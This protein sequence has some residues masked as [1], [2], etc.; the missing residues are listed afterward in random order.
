MSPHPRTSSPRGLL[1]LLSTLLVVPVGAALLPLVAF[2]A[3][4]AAGPDEATPDPA[5]TGRYGFQRAEYDLPKVDVGLGTPG[6]TSTTVLSMREAG[7]VYYP[8]TGAGPFPV[9]VFEHG[10]HATCDS[11]STA[12][13]LLVTGGPG[14]LATFEDGDCSTGDATADAA[15]AI[16]EARSYQGYDYLAQ[17]LATQGYIVAS[18]DVNDITDWTNNAAESGY[19]A[20]A[21]IISKTLDLVGSWNTRTGPAGIGDG[22]RGR[23]GLGLGVGVMGHSRGGEGVNMFAEYNQTRP[24]T[25]A[26]AASRTDPEN[27]DLAQPVPDVGPRYDLEAVFSLA[28]V[29]DQGDRRPVVSGTNFATLLPYCDGDV[30]DLEG[31]PVFERSKDGLTASGYAAAQYVVNGANHNYFNTV[32]T[33]DDANLFGFGDPNCNAEAGPT[34]LQPAE[35]RQVGLT[36]IGGFLRYWVGGETQFAPIVRGES[37]PPA[38]CPNDGADPVAGVSCRNIVQTSYEAPNRLVLVEPTGTSAAPTVPTTTPAGDPITA[39]GLTMT[40]CTPT[41]TAVAATT[42]CGSSPNRS[43]GPQLSLSWTAASALTVAPQAAHRDISAF[44]TL[45]FRI[46]PNFTDP[47]QLPVE[48]D[49]TVSL[50]DTSGKGATVSSSSYSAALEPPPGTSARK[51]LLHGVRIPLSAFTGIDLTSIKTISLG[52][53]TSALS[54]GSVQLNDLVLQEPRSTAGTD[55]T[56]TTDP[57][58]PAE[59]DPATTAPAPATT[60]TASAAAVPAGVARTRTRTRIRLPRPFQTLGAKPA[61]LKFQVVAAQVSPAS[62]GRVVVRVDGK[63]VRTLDAPVTSKAG[64]SVAGFTYRMSRH[65]SVGTHTVRVRFR[66]TDATRYTASKSRLITLTVTGPGRARPRNAV[67]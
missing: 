41:P 67:G 5:T 15:L 37:L 54:S 63:K 16:Q 65:L 21:Q 34:R 27:P 52:F 36:L 40:A 11:G 1:R 32:W 13:D 3:P 66:P 61:T 53:G 55:P 46:A 43:A 29:D 58:G 47:R 56:E 60:T 49:V 26:E 31:A 42:G 51:Q 22:L 17:Q 39:T 24:A 4:A 35:Q 10:N 45:N 28:P 38:V 18:I 14:G 19:L 12:D 7:D 6:A 48:S 50:V 57:T 44:A 64:R 25:V 8:A 30:Y 23:V 20:R 62:A 9:L 33:A 59:T 2:S